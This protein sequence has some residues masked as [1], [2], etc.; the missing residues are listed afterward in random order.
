MLNDIIKN[1]LNGLHI[2]MA[3]IPILIFFLPINMV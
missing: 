2:A 3:L 1:F